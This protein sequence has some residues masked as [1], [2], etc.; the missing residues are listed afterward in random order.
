MP[1]KT[2]T[3]NDK[4]KYKRLLFDNAGTTGDPVT[5]GKLISVSETPG[6]DGVTT[7]T[8]KN[9][10]NSTAEREPDNQPYWMWDISDEI[11]WSDNFNIEIAIEYTTST[12]SSDDILSW[13]GIASDTTQ[14]NWVTRGIWHAYRHSTT[15]N[16]SPFSGFWA[17]GA[18]F[19]TSANLNAEHMYSRLHSPKD[20]ISRASLG[21]TRLI[22]WSMSAANDVRSGRAISPS[23]SSDPVYICFTAG[24]MKN[25]AFNGGANVVSHFRLW[26]RTIN[27]QIE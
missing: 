27:Y 21:G 12:S 6:R 26:Y 22:D 9:G 24:S 1:F 18:F 10:M 5:G 7:V 20:Y 11:S 23:T 8:L 15:F 16:T 2:L 3:I 13:A 14:A 25:V 19:F 17:D 4:T